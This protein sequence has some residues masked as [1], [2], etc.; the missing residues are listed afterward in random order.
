MFFAISLME[1][2]TTEISFTEYWCV[3]DNGTYAPFVI[4][5]TSNRYR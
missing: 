2:G 1:V 5:G 3:L 4:W